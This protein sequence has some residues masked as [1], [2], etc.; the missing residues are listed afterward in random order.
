MLVFC[1]S[2]CKGALLG[3]KVIEIVLPLI[4]PSIY[5]TKVL[6]FLQ[7]KKSLKPWAILL[8]LK[9]E[10]EMCQNRQK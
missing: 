10:I 7:K 8:T 6:I 4:V 9:I 5:S 1:L 3:E 2:P